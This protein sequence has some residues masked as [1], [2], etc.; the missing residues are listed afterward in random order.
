LL[1]ILEEVLQIS[2]TADVLRD[3]LALLMPYAVEI[4][5]PDEWFQPSA[6]DAREARQ[7]AEEVLG[8]LR[9]TLPSL[10]R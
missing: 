6:D 1:A 7:A 8:W 2:S 9:A 4:R 10:L 3:D 5:Y